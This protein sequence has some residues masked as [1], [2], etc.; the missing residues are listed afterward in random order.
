MRIVTRMECPMQVCVY[1][2]TRARTR[3]AG[4][5]AEPDP[6]LEA[7]DRP[8]GSIR[9][10]Q[11]LDTRSIHSSCG[12]GKRFA[13]RHPAGMTIGRQ[14]PRILSMTRPSS[15]GDIADGTGRHAESV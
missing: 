2:P 5:A 1:D 14:A 8:S 13:P 7:M 10:L 11:R 4:I 9:G 12:L 15:A 3:S 6:F